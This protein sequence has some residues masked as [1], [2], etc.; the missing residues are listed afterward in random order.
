MGSA[1]TRKSVSFHSKPKSRGPIPTLNTGVPI[2]KYRAT[3]K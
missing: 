3:M 1:E 2:P